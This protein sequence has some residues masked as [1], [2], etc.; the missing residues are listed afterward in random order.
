MQDCCPYEYKLVLEK[1][2]VRGKKHLIPIF[3]SA[4]F[5][6]LGYNEQ[7][8]FLKFYAKKWRVKNVQFNKQQALY[9]YSADEP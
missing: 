2:C 6:C 4:K 1:V 9:R 3:L 5:I 7:K 8:A